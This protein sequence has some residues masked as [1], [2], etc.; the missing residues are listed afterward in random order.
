MPRPKRCR[1]ICCFPDYWEFSPATDEVGRKSPGDATE[2]VVMT[3]EE[4]EAVRLIDHEKLTQQQCAEQMEVART[5]VTAI[6]DSARGKLADALVNG[7]TLRISGGDYRLSGSRPD[8]PADFS[9]KGSNTMR[10]AAAYEDGMIFQHFGHTEQFKIYD[11]E[12]G[13]IRR[14]TVIPVRGA[15]HGALAGF[16][17]EAEVDALICGGIGGGAR[18]ALAEA[19]I[20]LYPGVSGPAD[21][22]ARALAAGTLDYNPETVCSH[23]D[24]G[25]GGGC[26]HGENHGHGGGCGHGE[27]HGHS[28][29]CGHGGTCRH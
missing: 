27:N 18:T 16:L 1:R 11:I 7:K 29:D 4:Y 22:A 8:L 24:H 17:K 13:E 20:A 12:D 19:G 6:Y 15:G 21:E 10:L 3:L 5:T 23:H 25:H 9:E 26:G 2:T 28:G 14:E